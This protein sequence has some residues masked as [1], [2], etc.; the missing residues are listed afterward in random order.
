MQWGGA[1]QPAHIDRGTDWGM[2]RIGGYRGGG[3][4]SV[5]VTFSVVGV[6]DD[7]LL[8]LRAQLAVGCHSK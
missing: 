4:T 7:L 3:R 5:A 1:P 6:C 8:G 2:L